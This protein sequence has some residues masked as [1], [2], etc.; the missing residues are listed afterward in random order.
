MS[1][2]SRSADANRQISLGFRVSHFH[3]ACSARRK[4]EKNIYRSKTTLS[5]APSGHQNQYSV[6]LYATWPYK[7]IADLINRRCF[8]HKADGVQ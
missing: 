6:T 1:K 5:L 4:G 3:N 2:N 7:S 8:F